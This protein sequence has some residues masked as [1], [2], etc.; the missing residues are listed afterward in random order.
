MT[1]TF[2]CA[3]CSAPLEFEGS[4]MQKCRFCGSTVVVPAEM[5]YQKTSAVPPLSAGGLDDVIER[6]KKIAEAARLISDGRKIEAIKLLRDEFRLGLK[7]AKDA[8]DAI[9]RGE[10]VQLGGMAV[11]SGSQPPAMPAIAKKLG[12]AVESNTKKIFVFALLPVILA[13]IGIA[14]AVVFI[15]STRLRTPSGIASDK[16]R[17]AYEEVM[18]LGGE[19]NGAGRFKDN[20]VVAVDAFGRIYSADYSGSKVQVFDG[21][22]QFQTRWDAPNIVIAMVVS[23]DGTVFILDSGAIRKF[24]GQTGAKLGELPARS[25][26]GLAMSL[27]RDLAVLQNDSIVVYDQSLGQKRRLDKIL[28]HPELKQPEHLAIDGD[29][30]FFVADRSS[31]TIFKFSRDGTFLD[32]FGEAN[33]AITSLAVDPKGRIFASSVSAINVYAPDGRPLQKIAEKQA[34]G[35]AFDTAGNLFVASRPYVVKYRLDL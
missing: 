34:F 2:K 22:G 24:N 19:G 17:P 12:T 11:S 29:G 35:I 14:A 3:A 21:N 20:R 1:T 15:G 33:I 18:R 9:E 4:T 8:A 31:N 6:A 7:E 5:F 26:K 32:R 16:T 27:D 23:L 10:S 30:N 25:V 28:T 13:V